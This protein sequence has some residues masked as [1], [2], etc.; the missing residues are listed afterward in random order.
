MYVKWTPKLRRYVVKQVR[1]G[2][3]PI[4]EI[5]RNRHV[6]RRTIY[7]LLKRFKFGGFEA[8]E[9]NQRGRKKEP[10]N[11]RFVQFVKDE[12]NAHK[13]GS[14]KL[15][16]RL[17]SRGF[18]VSQRKIQEIYTE[19]GFKLN[20]RSRPSQIKFVKYEY[21]HPNDLWHA[22]WT[23]D[24]ATGQNLIAFLDDCTR[25][26]IH[27]EIFAHATAENTILAFNNAI[28]RHG[29][30]DA[31]LTDNGTQF[32]PARTEKGP[33]TQW[34]KEN[35]I[36]H[37]LGRIHH[38]QTNGKVER[39]FGTYKQEYDERFV[40]LEQYLK[41]YNEERLH[42]GIGYLTPMEKWNKL[43]CANNSV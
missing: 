41:Y 32:T 31:I 17:K 12:W 9:P 6:P 20:K 33:F 30:P 19:E 34:C 8:L 25:V 5:A 37:I 14:H 10:L 29:K 35:G 38:P 40:C 26:L 15:W 11:P 3:T 36:K 24:S 1:L 7:Y 43:K 22:D 2:I 18:S 21:P 16:L 27:A 4:T 39:W 42:Q 23:V 13:L 28:T